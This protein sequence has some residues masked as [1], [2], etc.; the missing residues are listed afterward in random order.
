MREDSVSAAPV[1]GMRDL[2]VACREYKISIAVLGVLGLVLGLVITTVSAPVYR[3]EALLSPV[4]DQSANTLQQLAGQFGGL[5]QIAGVNVQGD[6]NLWEAL[7][8][9]RSR[10][11]TEEFIRER[12]LLPVIFSGAW[13][14]DQ[15]R[16]ADDVADDPPT[17][18]DAYRVFDEQIR[19]VDWNNTS[20]LVTLSVRWYDPHVAAEWANALVFEVN[21]SLRERAIEEAERSVEYLN[22]ELGGT[23]VVGLQQAIY[24]LIESQ[25]NT[26]M[27]ANVRKEFAFKV[28][29]PAVAPDSDDYI[30]PRGFLLVAGGTVLGLGFGLVLALMRL[31]WRREPV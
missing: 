24:S 27:L 30:W 14:A 4:R 15:G 19:S 26:G 10:A 3:V 20:R 22:N 21:E 28:I 6:E 7:E 1:V 8:T 18:N 29:D 17:M 25:I 31:L 2:F 11:L 12:N 9:L 23:S 16:W 5:A 13:N